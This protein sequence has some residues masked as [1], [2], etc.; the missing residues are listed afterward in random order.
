MRRTTAVALVSIALVSTAAIVGAYFLMHKPEPSPGEDLQQRLH[1]EKTS[2]L[3]ASGTWI[4]G[5]NADGQSSMTGYCEPSEP[6]TP[7]PVVASPSSVAPAEDG[8]GGGN[9]CFLY[10]RD[11]PE[12][13]SVRHQVYKSTGYSLHMPL[14]EIIL[15]GR[16]TCRAFG[17]KPTDPELFLR[18]AA[19]MAQA[20]DIPQEVALR[21]VAALYATFC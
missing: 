10:V 16:A 4:A 7:A 12:A 17:P 11:C 13:R 2:C 19:N 14:L 18:V 3:E 6:T 9:P 5:E 8:S 15:D 20:K 1:E 21:Y